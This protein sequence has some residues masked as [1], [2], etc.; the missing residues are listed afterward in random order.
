MGTKYSFG[1]SSNNED[2]VECPELSAFLEDINAV[3]ERHGVGLEWDR[4][5]EGYDKIVLVPFARHDLDFTA[6]L[7]DYSGGV[8]WLDAAK[9]NFEAK[10]KAR[11]AQPSRSTAAKASTKIR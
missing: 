6:N 7:S 10:R 11:A 2:D 9:A 8:P 4:D 1:W 5:Y 3:L